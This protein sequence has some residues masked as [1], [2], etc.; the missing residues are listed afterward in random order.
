MDRAAVA[1]APARPVARAGVEPPDLREGVLAHRSAAVGRA[2]QP[3]VVE[4]DQ[5]LVGGAADVQLD[6]VGAGGDGGAEAGQGVLRRQQA[7][8]PVAE[9]A[10]QR[11]LLDGV[12]GAR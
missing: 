12:D 5:R 7:G 3:G 11:D 10:R 1:V 6:A 4:A 2:A 9:D 8:A